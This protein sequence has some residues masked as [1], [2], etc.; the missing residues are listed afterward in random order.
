LKIF[1]G[2]VLV[3]VAISLLFTGCAI[4]GFAYVR[5]INDTEID[6]VEN[7]GELYFIVYRLQVMY[8]Y[9]EYWLSFEE[10]F[11]PTVP[12]DHPMNL[13]VVWHVR[14]TKKGTVETKLIV[15]SID[16]TED[17]GFYLIKIDYHSGMTVTLTEPPPDP[18]LPPR[19]WNPDGTLK[20]PDGTE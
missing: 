4:N 20:Y 8:D 7:S 1:C 15:Y 2:V 18:Y 3:I 14:N 17:L 16:V 19:Y 11:A 10:Y 6:I 9:Q 12:I 13:E 5:V